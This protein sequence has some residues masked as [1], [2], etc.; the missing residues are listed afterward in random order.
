MDWNS[1]VKKIGNIF[2]AIVSVA[3]EVRV[4][5]GRLNELV[6]QG[7]EI[8]ASIEAV[9][10]EIKNRSLPSSYDMY[11]QTNNPPPG[12]Q[13]QYGSPVTGPVNMVDMMG[14]LVASTQSTQAE[15]I[16][17]L[18]AQFNNEVLAILKQE[19]AELEVGN[20]KLKKSIEHLKELLDAELKAK[21]ELEDGS[22]ESD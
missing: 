19:N 21:K 5:A 13:D 2:N 20:R 14:Y 9:G 12:L 16:S 22:S 7:K 15:L 8:V 1:Q 18:G 3:T 6:E 11:L 4:V 10:N 17:R